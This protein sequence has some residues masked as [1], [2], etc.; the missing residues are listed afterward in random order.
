MHSNRKVSS[1]M[2]MI[3]RL[4]SLFSFPILVVLLSVVSI[5]V[6]PMFREAMRVSVKSQEQRLHAE[7]NVWLESQK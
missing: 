4:F 7:Y 1:A 5:F 3:N 2:K 6:P